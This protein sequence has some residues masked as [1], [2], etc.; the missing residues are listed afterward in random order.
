MILNA[1]I[2]N[3]RDWYL[4]LLIQNGA[5][6][7]PGVDILEKFPPGVT[8]TQNTTPTLNVTKTQ[9]A[10]SN[11]SQSTTKNTQGTTTHATMAFI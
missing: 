7:L 2:N 11:S 6:L 8:L 9:E 10:S 3:D 5:K 4:S 1:L